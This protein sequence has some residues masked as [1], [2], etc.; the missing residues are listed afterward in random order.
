MAKTVELHCEL[1]DHTWR[2]KS[3]RGR[4]P[5]NCPKHRPEPVAAKP[6]GPETLICEYGEGHEW[7]RERTRGR[8]PKMCPE[9]REM[10]KQQVNGEPKK[11]TGRRESTAAEIWAKL[12]T[13]PG[14]SKCR[15]DLTPDMSREELIDKGSG[16]KDNFVCTVLDRYRRL[17]GI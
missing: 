5:K 16:C 11:K 1:G 4:V 3:Q 12:E 10:V 6:E 17:V 7:E 13:T 14:F 9:H 2:R 8:A 15:C